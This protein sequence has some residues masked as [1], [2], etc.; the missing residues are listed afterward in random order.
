M[1]RHIKPA[2]EANGIHKKNGWHSFRHAF[3]TLLKASGENVKTVQELLRH[4]NSRITFDVYTQVVNSNKRAAQ[5]KV[6]KMAVSSEGTKVA[7]LGT[8]DSTRQVQNA[9]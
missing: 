3:G 2:A 8:T 6:L 1:N 4:A 9:A 7:G 5:S